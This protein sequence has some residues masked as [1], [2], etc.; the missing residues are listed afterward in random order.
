MKEVPNIL[1]L[2]MKEFRV[3]HDM[4]LL[5]MDV[6][7][8]WLEYLDITRYSLKQKGTI[9]ELYAYVRHHGTSQS[10]HYTCAIKRKHPFEKSKKVWV[11]FDD[12]MT[13][14]MDNEQNNIDSAYLLFFKRVDMPTSGFVN[15]T[16][17]QYVGVWNNDSN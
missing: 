2:H 8:K 10:G 12:D 3:T 15:F 14:L 17:M 13:L 16:N 1:V 6:N 5:K 11:N 7:L 9:Y 4:T